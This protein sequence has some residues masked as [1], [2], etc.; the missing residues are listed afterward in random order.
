MLTRFGCSSLSVMVLGAIAAPANADVAP[1]GGEVLALGLFPVL[2]AVL[3][4]AGLG[5]FFYRRRR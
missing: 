4:G 2:L 5:I 3:L 1:P